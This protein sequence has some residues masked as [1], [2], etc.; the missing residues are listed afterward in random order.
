[1]PKM[2]AEYEVSERGLQ[3]LPWADET[4]EYAHLTSNGIPV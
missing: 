3:V 4:I 1:M 2:W